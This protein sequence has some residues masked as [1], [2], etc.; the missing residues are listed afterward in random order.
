[1]LC[2]VGRGVEGTLNTLRSFLITLNRSC[3]R[4]RAIKDRSLV[5]LPM[6]H[7]PTTQPACVGPSR[8][9]SVLTHRENEVQQMRTQSR[10]PALAL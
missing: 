8:L 6:E 9:C 3:P 4:L 2:V 10:L 1:M 7:K 5:P